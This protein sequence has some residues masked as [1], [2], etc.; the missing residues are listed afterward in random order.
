MEAVWQRGYNACPSWIGKRE[1]V[2]VTETIATTEQL[3]A[4]WREAERTLDSMDPFTPGRADVEARV[5]E[6]RAAYRAR[7]SSIRPDDKHAGGQPTWPPLP[8]P[9][10]AR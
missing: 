2:A 4:A 3:L 9:A 10:E 5:A 7:V 6:A 8:E 1:G